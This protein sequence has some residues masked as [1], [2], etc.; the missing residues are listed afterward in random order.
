MSAELMKIGGESFREIRENGCCYV[1]KTGFIAELLPW[2]S[3]ASLIARPPKFGMTLMLDMLAEFLDIRRDSRAIFDGLAVSK[4]KE[5]C[6][7]WMNQH[8]TVLV[9]FKSVV[10]PTYEEAVEQIRKCVSELYA[11]FSFPADSPAIDSF[12][13]RQ[14]E[15]LKAGK[16]SRAVLSGSLYALCRLLRMHYG[17]RAIVLVDAYDVPLAK[18]QENGYYREMIDFLRRMLGSALKGNESLEFGI[19]AGCLKMTSG[20][21]F[22]GFNNLTYS[23]IS[24]VRYDDKFGF[25]S[26]EVDDLLDA[27]GFPEKKDIVKEWYGGY[28]IG[29]ETDLCCPQSVLQY[30]DDLQHDP[31]AMPRPYRGSTGGADIMR[32]LLEHSHKGFQYTLRDLMTGSCLGIQINDMLSYDSLYDYDDS[33]WS[34]LYFAGYLTKASPEQMDKRKFHPCEGDVVL[35][36]PNKEV[37][38]IYGCVTSSLFREA[39]QKEDRTELFEVFWA[40]DAAGLTERLEWYLQTAVSSYNIR[41]DYYQAFLAE[42]FSCKEWELCAGGKLGLG[43]PA[44][45]LRDKS[46]ARAAVIEVRRAE[47][48]EKLPSAAEEAL[49]QAESSQ[50]AKALKAEQ[51]EAVS[52]WGMAFYKYRCELRVKVSAMHNACF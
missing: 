45:V 18:A 34:F 1:D 15:K 5:L 17:K 33:R 27:A 4:D 35:V 36:V 30:I 32:G 19:L 9:S 6:D 12:D 42:L 20:T 37:L 26:R 40:E 10:G 52:L 14:L 43:S 7:E 48:C 8:P 23:D 47:S 16:G 39:V 24:S 3:K 41:T 51:Y 25:T 28:Q 11:S 50:Y 13:K 21:C 2:S 38:G 31:N 46:S 29:K 44:V 22:S 49:S